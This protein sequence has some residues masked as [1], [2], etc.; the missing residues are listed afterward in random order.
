MNEYSQIWQTALIEIK[1]LVS[2]ANYSTWLTTTKILREEEGVIY[3]GVPNEFTREWLTKKCHNSILR[4]LRQ[5]NDRVRA[6]DYVIM[7]DGEAKPPH[8]R[9]HYVSDHIH[10]PAGFLYQQGRQPES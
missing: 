4:I 9:E 7:K 6:L 3:L 1:T 8:K 10:A 5:L 2:P